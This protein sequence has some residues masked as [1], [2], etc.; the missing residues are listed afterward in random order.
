MGVFDEPGVVG[1]GRRLVGKGFPGRV[2]CPKKPAPLVLAVSQTLGS[3]HRV[4]GSSA[5]FRRKKERRGEP[6]AS[7][8]GGI[9]I[10]KNQVGDVVAGD[11]ALKKGLILAN[12]SA[13]IGG[14]P[15][16]GQRVGVV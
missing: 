7:I 8:G 4:V 15:I 12:L 3:V 1:T 9:L 2:I 10:G 13:N 14:G 6:P 11:V 5:A 16:A